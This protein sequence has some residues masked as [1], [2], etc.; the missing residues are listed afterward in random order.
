[1]LKEMY[2]AMK[3]AHGLR[4]W[5]PVLRVGAAQDDRPT[6]DPARKR[7]TELQRFEIAVGAILTQNTAWSNVE[8]AMV[9]LHRC[10]AISPKRLNVMPP[11]RLAKLIRS[12]GYF[13]Q[14]ARKLKAFV[15]FLDMKT[16]GVEPMNQL[17]RMQ[18]RKIR[19]ELLGVHGVGP[20]TADSILLYALGKPVFV[21]DAYT[22]RIFSRHGWIRG[23]EPYDA[24]RKWF[25]G[26]LPKS[27]RLYNEYHAQIV[28][29]GKRNCHR[30]RPDC[31]SCPLYRRGFFE[32]AEDFKRVMS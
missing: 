13:N 32:S 12:S 15:R 16:S 11:P 14:K 31:R 6:Y 4:G 24:I 27:P 7:L 23:D 5:W 29:I 21:V 10:G 3:R 9:Q 18:T 26:K 17:K 25:E 8:K 19:A 1:M 2:L 28:E 30:R 22:R 20:E